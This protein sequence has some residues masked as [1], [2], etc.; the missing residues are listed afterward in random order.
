MA[1]V[2]HGE[3]IGVRQRQ[4][5]HRPVVAPELVQRGGR[6]R[7]GL[8]VVVGERHA[9]GEAGGPRGVEDHR[10]VVGAPVHG[11][12]HVRLSRGFRGQR[13]R[14]AVASSVDQQDVVQRGQD[15]DL[16]LDLPEH[17]GGR[18]HHLG[19][20]VGHDVGD[21]PLA[22]QE[23]HRDDD[24]AAPEDGPVALDHLG[25]IREHHEHAIPGADTEAPQSVGQPG[26]GPRLLQIGVPAPLERQRDVLAVLVE[27]LVREA[28]EGHGS[29][30]Q[31][32]MSFKRL[33]V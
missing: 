30:H 15:A 27:A 9:L 2:H 31:F 16:R 4:H 23:D 32:A 33:P 25:A 21:L 18:D 26:G 14:R 19:L 13:A 20:G 5:R 29:G 8:E 24:A 22:Q 10:E 3:A 1:R 28:S 11:G 7:V 6:A 12:E 17:V